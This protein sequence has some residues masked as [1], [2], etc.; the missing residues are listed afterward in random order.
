[1]FNTRAKQIVQNL[2]FISKHEKETNGDTQYIY[3]NIGLSLWRSS[4][5]TEETMREDWFKEMCKENQEEE[6][7]YFYFQTVA[8]YPD[9]GLYYSGLI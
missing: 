8:V 5:F 1:M 7:R 4:V 9:D 3:A 6:M 2:N